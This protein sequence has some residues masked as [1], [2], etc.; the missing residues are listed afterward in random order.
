[1]YL[2]VDLCYWQAYDIMEITVI[3]GKSVNVEAQHTNAF[4]GTLQT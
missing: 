4:Q 3:C 2:S 1:M